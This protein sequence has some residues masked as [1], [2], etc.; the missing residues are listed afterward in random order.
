[1]TTNSFLAGSPLKREWI[2]EL[3]YSLRLKMIP[4]RRSQF[5]SRYANDC[6][7][8]VAYVSPKGLLRAGM[9]WSRKAL[10]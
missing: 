7:V 8:F 6:K 10:A 3:A 5:T 4:S 2:F 1:M 9:R